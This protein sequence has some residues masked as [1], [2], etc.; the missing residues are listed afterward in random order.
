[1][2]ICTEA[3]NY[4]FLLCKASGELPEL[5]GIKHSLDVI[6]DAG[7]VFQYCSLKKKKQSKDSGLIRLLFILQYNKLF[8]RASPHLY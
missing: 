2:I 5:H 6:N 8:T 4:H 7:E 1:M 3:G